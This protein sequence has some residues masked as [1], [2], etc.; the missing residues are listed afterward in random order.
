MCQP[1]CVLKMKSSLFRLWHEF[2]E[3][4]YASRASRTELLKSESSLIPTSTL[5]K[6]LG[7]EKMVEQGKVTLK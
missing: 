1:Y 4:E 5:C 6:R 2:Q 3:N 7:H